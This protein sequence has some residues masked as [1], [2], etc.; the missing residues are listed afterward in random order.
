MEG[1]RWSER[2]PSFLRG[3]AALLRKLNCEGEVRVGRGGPV[4]ERGG[5]E[6]WERGGKDTGKKKR[7]KAHQECQSLKT[8]EK[9]HPILEHK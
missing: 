4:I 3:G 9:D 7:E 6:T 2:K 5:R 1:G 8:G